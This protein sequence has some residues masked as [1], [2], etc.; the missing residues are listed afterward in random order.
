MKR[1]T[2]IIAVLLGLFGLSAV[3]VLWSGA[4]RSDHL[5][6]P[7]WKT[8]AI[9]MIDISGPIDAGNGGVFAP[10]GLNSILDQIHAHRDDDRVKALIVRINSP[11]G[12]VG[13]SQEIYQELK[14]FKSK[15]HKPVIVSVADLGASGAYWVALAGDVIVANPGSMVGSVGVIMS[16]PDFQ[17]VP[18]RYGIGMRTVKSGK[19]K[20]MF[21]SW[22]PV[23]T[24]EKAMMQSMLDDVHE[25]FISVLILERGIATQSALV[26]AQG[27]VFS[28]RQAV[29]LG[30]ID[31]L[32]G[33]SDAID[34]AK[35]KAKLGKD[36]EIL[37]KSESSMQ[38]LLQQY[39]GSEVRSLMP[40]LQTVS[41][42]K[43][44]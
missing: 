21:N 20:D 40:D 33:L 35:R 37:Q 26:I 34:I 43:I 32:G 29:D 6:R 5:A 41:T 18:Q 3:S 38:E 15:T 24:E 12:T 10:G 39:I 30:L 27:Q 9:G 14:K 36:V 1:E 28:G 42:P 7:L 16:G 4:R 8:P 23:T 44:Q 13:A 25:Q 17:Q 11:G 31:E 2:V 19:Y 22:R